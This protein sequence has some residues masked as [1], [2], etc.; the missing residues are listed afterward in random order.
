LADI[1]DFA[2]L[3]FANFLTLT[4]IALLS[5]AQPD[6]GFTDPEPGGARQPLAGAISPDGRYLYYANFGSADVWAFS[7]RIQ[8]SY[9][10]LVCSLYWSTLA[11]TNASSIAITP[12]GRTLYVANFGTSTIATFERDSDGRLRQVGAP[13]ASGGEHPDFQSI[14]VRPA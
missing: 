2:L 7:F 10:P 5:R 12:D 3:T 14:V 4:I 6:S 13:L 11:L 9:R 8:V 1:R